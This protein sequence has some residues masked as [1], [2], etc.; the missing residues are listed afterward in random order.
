[1]TQLTK[2]QQALI[3]LMQHSSVKRTTVTR[4]VVTGRKC[5]A[6]GNRAMDAANGLI[7][8]GR[9]KLVSR[10]HRQECR[11]GWSDTYTELTIELVTD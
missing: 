7:D 6:Y 11:R 5:R 4:G 3:A 10:E 1:M 2:T 9:A 8:L